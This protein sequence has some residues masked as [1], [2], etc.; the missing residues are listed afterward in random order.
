LARY[1]KIFEQISLEFE[2]FNFSMM[3]LVQT[4]L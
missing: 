1:E 3:K 2:G 4:V